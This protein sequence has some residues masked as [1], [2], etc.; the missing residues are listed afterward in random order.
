MIHKEPHILI[1]DDDRVSQ[2]YLEE[3]INQLVEGAHIARADT[4]EQAIGML[5]QHDFQFV[6]SDL[7][8]PGISGEELM[9]ELFALVEKKPDC[10][11]I[12]IS[13]MTNV[14]NKN[15]E[16][17]GVTLVLS[18]PV[19]GSVLKAIL[20]GGDKQSISDLAD[21]NLQIDELVHP[22][23]IF[24]L[25]KDK[26]EKVVNILKLYEQTLPGQIDQLKRAWEK[27]ELAALRNVAHSIKNSFSYLGVRQLKPVA[28]QIEDEALDNT[29]TE[30][31]GHLVEKINN[32]KQEI[33]QELSDLIKKYEAKD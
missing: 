13:G 30:H 28:K 19:D 33:Q 9:Q 23:K 10:K 29:K 5:K 18:K 3:L 31:L 32:N 11:L 6:F 26:P 27:K 7:L 16:E 25:Y 12:A 24:D 22:D 1:I 20:L 17:L 4:G 8:M 15:L 14:H 2:I 21:N